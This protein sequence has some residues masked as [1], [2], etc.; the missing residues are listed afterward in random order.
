MKNQTNTNFVIHASL[1]LA[2]ALAI[3]FPVQARSVEPAEGKDMTQAKMMERCQ[4]IK[5][6]NQKMTEDMKAQ[7]A[8]L[9]KQ[10]TEMNNAPDDKKMGLMATVITHMAKQ[11]IAM[12][13]RMAGW[14][15]R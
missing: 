11:G 12:D 13:A 5:A 1:A 10:L 3:W 7:D 8:E 15:R 4:E 6:Q 9:T 2:L 14:T